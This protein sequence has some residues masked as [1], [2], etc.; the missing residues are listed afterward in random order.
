MSEHAAQ[1]QRYNNELVNCV[2]KLRNASK[3]LEKDIIKDKKA[4]TEVQERINQLKK[5]EECLKEDIAKKKSKLAECNKALDDSETVYKTM[6]DTSHR[7]LHVLTNVH[8][9]T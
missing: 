2:E 1:L 8:S 7:L 6:L 5:E 9:K 4:L 3:A